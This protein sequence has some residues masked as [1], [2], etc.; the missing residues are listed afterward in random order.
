MTR[1]QKEDGTSKFRKFPF[2]VLI[3]K[4]K[5]LS[6]MRH[7]YSLESKSER[8][9]AAD[10]EYHSE[11]AAEIFNDALPNADKDVFGKPYWPSGIISLAIDP[12]YAPAILLKNIGARMS[13]NRTT[14][15]ISMT[16][17]IRYQKQESSMRLSLYLK[18][19]FF[20]RRRIMNCLLITW[21]TL[22][23]GEKKRNQNSFGAYRKKDTER[24]AI[25]L[26]SGFCLCEGFDYHQ[27]F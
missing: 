12:L 15:D 27:L 9:M 13:W 20:W 6:E 11:I 10:Y 1:K 4:D 14:A 3:K 25:L 7:E 17:V 5:D 21:R 16:W 2:S 8:R 26:A 19:Q 23:K 22:E 24:H 18:K